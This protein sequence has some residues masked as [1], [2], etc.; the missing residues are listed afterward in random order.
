MNLVKRNQQGIAVALQVVGDATSLPYASLRNAGIGN[1]VFLEALLGDFVKKIVLALAVAD[2]DDS[3]TRWHG[4][5]INYGC[6]V[7]K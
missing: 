2:Q 5:V 4:A 7:D 3:E 6:A 1:P